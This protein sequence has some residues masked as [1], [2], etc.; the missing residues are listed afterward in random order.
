MIPISD[1]KKV[2]TSCGCFNDIEIIRK[3]INTGFG[4]KCPIQSQMFHTK[5]NT[6]VY[7]EGTLD[8]SS[9]VQDILVTKDKSKV[10]EGQAI[11]NKWVE[12]LGVK[13]KIC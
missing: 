12:K 13:V 10:K 7:Y 4:N 3:V 6:P 8:V 2:L 1:A 11:F 9:H 5:Y